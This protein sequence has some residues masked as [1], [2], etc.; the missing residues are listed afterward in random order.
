[1]Y[2]N[3]SPVKIGKMVRAALLVCGA[4]L[5]CH[6]TPIQGL[7]MRRPVEA[8][9]PTSFEDLPL[10]VQ[11]SIVEKLPP[12]SRENHDLL[13]IRAV[14][15]ALREAA[16]TRPVVQRALKNGARRMKSMNILKRQLASIYALYPLKQE[17]LYELLRKWA[18]RGFSQESLSELCSGPDLHDQRLLL[19]GFEMC[20]RSARFNEPVR[21]QMG[22]EIM[23]WLDEHQRLSENSDTRSYWSELK[24]Q[25]DPFMQRT[26]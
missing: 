15:K 4:M 19:E 21:M 25:F 24:R 20:L 1:M 9:A 7:Q 26:R 16:G 2:Q 23:A 14:S 6:L 10:E 5:G 8:V 13:N 17:Q 22:H 11:S 12:L 3:V 18:S